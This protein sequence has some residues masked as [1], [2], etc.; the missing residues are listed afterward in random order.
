MRFKTIAGLL[1]V[2]LLL[3]AVQS[4]EVLLVDVKKSISKDKEVVLIETSGKVALPN[5]YPMEKDPSCLVLEFD[6]AKPSPEFAGKKNFKEGIIK[7]AEVKAE[8]GKTRV[9]LRFASLQPFS[10]YL[11]DRG[12]SV[13]VRKKG[14][15][16]KAKFS[17]ADRALMEE[18]SV[19]KKS[20][21]VEVHID[22][23]PAV[24]SYRE[25]ML[26]RDEAHNKPLR[27]VI[28]F[29]NT[30]ARRLRR[31]INAAGVAQLR[32][33]QFNP[34]TARVVFD[35]R[36]KTSYRLERL[37][38]N[39]LAVIFPAGKPAE[40]KPVKIVFNTPKET[41]P[42]Q[43]G[44]D[45]EG[46]PAVQQQPAQKSKSKEVKTTPQK[47]IRKVIKGEEKKYYGERYT[48]RFKDADLRDVLRFIARIANLNIIFDPGV[49]G[50]VTCDLVD[51]P[52]DQALELIL[53]A[54]K[55]GYTIEGNVLRIAKMEVLAQEEEERRKLQ[56]AAAPLKV[57]TRAL[58][59]ANA[60]D[61]TPILQKYLSGRGEIVVD[62]RTNTLII[63]DIP[64]NIELM[65]RLIDTLDT[66]IPQVS[67]E[68]RIVE[69]I[70]TFTRNLGIQWGFMAY[71][72]PYFGNQ[73]NLVFP[74]KIT[75]DGSPITGQIGG[76]TDNPLNGYAVNLPAPAFN[77]ALGISLGNVTDSFALDLALTA[78]EQQGYGRIL[79][80][81]RI[82]TEDNKEAHIMQGRQIPVQTVI[83]N[84]I[85]V[86]YVPAALELKVTP[87]I[88]PEGTII[89]DINIQNNSADFSNLVNG[90][91]PIITQSARTCVLV[92]DGGTAVIGGIYR[93]E[94]STTINK[95]P[96]LHSIPIIG[97]LL[98]RGSSI[99]RENRELLIFITPRI[100][101]K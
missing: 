48:F 69:T 22:F 43:E 16:R 53:K 55:L 6:G 59:Y 95:T 92:K 91:P 84:T 4:G 24:P 83:N 31:A 60:R 72:N 25:F 20:G 94:D 34:R 51:V 21:S 52:W 11:I 62:E 19:Y 38:E 78:L 49:S 39:T 100:V 68:A 57:I 66:P 76:I 85:M 70:S 41:V 80:A 9:L 46:D 74:N 45:G 33:A 63:K 56:E 27:L 17:F 61:I 71:A 47:P 35:L 75:I 32:I 87:H 67:I 18:V 89:M 3:A 93:I 99:K 44:K 65:D 37:D 98:F 14:V 97:K 54:N 88:T 10:I 77:S 12:V 26:D 42:Q 5:F 8:G 50:K 23:S 36:E 82:T 79:S 73:T 30:T 2:S 101:K 86:R 81:P 13:E 28:D 29:N 64:A 96:F 7:E 1:A 90:I 58:S 15:A 40:E